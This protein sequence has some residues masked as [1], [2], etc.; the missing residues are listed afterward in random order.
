L[1]GDF[2]HLG[3]IGYQVAFA[4]MEGKLFLE[5]AEHHLKWSLSKLL[6]LETMM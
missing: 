2:S 5:I 3:F 4:L 1:F 6:L